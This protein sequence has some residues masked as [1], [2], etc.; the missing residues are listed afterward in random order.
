MSEADALNYSKQLVDFDLNVRRFA[1]RKLLELK[2]PVSLPYLIQALT[3]TDTLVRTNAENTLIAIGPVD[4]DKIIK[5]TSHDDAEVR[6]RLLFVYKQYN[7]INKL[8]GLIHLLSDPDLDVKNLAISIF[9]KKLSKI[10][11]DLIW[12]QVIDTSNHMELRDLYRDI[13][14]KRIIGIEDILINDLKNANLDDFAY[15]TACALYVLLNDK[16]NEFFL[17]K[18]D[19]KYYEE[20]IVSLH[21]NGSL[22][23]SQIIKIAKN[24][25]EDSE[26]EV[27]KIAVQ[28]I[29]EYGNADDLDFLNQL[30]NTPSAGVWKIG[31]EAILKIQEKL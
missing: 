11:S 6:L 25:T 20:R 30:K 13:L 7:T 5:G 24:A 1:V 28:L 16:G 31:K 18:L 26:S 27:R 9:N 17:D 10:S 4:I 3:D 14:V 22:N 2:H 21:S 8:E 19:S 29:G 12:K 23:Q 15:K